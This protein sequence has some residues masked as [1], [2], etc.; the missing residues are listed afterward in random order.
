MNI[1]WVTTSKFKDVGI[2]IC[3]ACEN[4][5]RKS[6]VRSLLAL[7]MSDRCFKYDTKLK[8]SAKQNE[9][10][11]CNISAASSSYGYMNKLEFK[12]RFLK[13]TIIQNQNILQECLQY[14]H[15]LIYHPLLNED[16]FKENQKLLKNKLDR[17]EDDV[18]SQIIYEGFKI[19]GENYP[20]A[21]N[22]YG[23]KELIDSI[24]LQ[25]VIDEHRDLIENQIVHMIV[26]C[27]QKDH[28][29]EQLLNQYFNFKERNLDL[30]TYYTI[31]NQLEK[32]EYHIEK[33]IP[34]SEILIVYNTNIDRNNPK[35]KVL[36]LANAL[37]GKY[38]TSLLFQEVREKRGLCYSIGSNL[39]S[40]DGVLYMS[41]GVAHDKVKECIEVMKEQVN[42]IANGDFSDELLLITKQMYKDSLYSAQDYLY[43]M[44]SQEYMSIVLNKAFDIEKACANI[45]AITKEEM[46]EVFKGL[47]YQMTM[48]IGKGK[49]C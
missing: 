45:D 5:Q 33:D 25:D 19:C 4:Q 13:P 22:A 9:L 20:L 2:S 44:I 34:Q 27:D 16:V 39:I 35:S 1:S 30:K 17:I 36:A 37:L 24:T 23:D 18:K 7:M 43:Y 32:Q 3:F 11:S 48:T 14:L 8:M 12:M 46:M 26:C 49:T 31:D 15:E 41:V 38:A 42:R 6:V 28:Y 40:F 10:Y 47:K 29:F 21:I